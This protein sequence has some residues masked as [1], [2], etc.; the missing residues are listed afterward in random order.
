[1]PRPEIIFMLAGKPL[2]DGDEIELRSSDDPGW[3]KIVWERGNIPDDATLG[4]WREVLRD[5]PRNVDYDF[6]RQ[7]FVSSNDALRWQ[8]E[9]IEGGG[10]TKIARIVLLDG[11]VLRDGD[12]LEVFLENQWTTVRWTVGSDPGSEP[13]GIARGNYGKCMTLESTCEL[14]W[15][16]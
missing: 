9:G 14:R 13:F 11:R 16:S 5:Y 7:G 10:W 4:I 2:R 8:S 12:T 15:P 3:I 1:M 6:P